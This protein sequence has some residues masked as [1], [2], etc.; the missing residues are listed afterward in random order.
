MFKICDITFDENNHYQ[1][2]EINV[3]QLISESFLK[4]NILNILKSNLKFIKI[5]FDNDEKLSELMSIEIII[6]NLLKT[7]ESISKDDKKY[8]SLSTSFSLKEKN[9]L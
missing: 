3:A 2:H 5:E 6:V 7:K 1:S 9:T 8:L 4:N